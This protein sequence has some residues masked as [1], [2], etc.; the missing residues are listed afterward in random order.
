VDKVRDRGGVL[1]TF[2]TV[3]SMMWVCHTP[4]R[5]GRLS[6][7]V[8]NRIMKFRASPELEARMLDALVA[9]NETTCGEPVDMSEWI[10]QCVRERLDHAARARQ[11]RARKDAKR[12]NAGIG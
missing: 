3:F 6:M 11:G 10:R 9:Y 12:R 7:S 8:G 4:I 5:K 2:A 1:W